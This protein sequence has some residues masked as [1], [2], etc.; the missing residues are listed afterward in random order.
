MI[1][2]LEF[3]KIFIEIL[4]FIS[5]YSKKNFVRPVADILTKQKRGISFISFA[6]WG[7]LLNQ[8]NLI[9]NIHVVISKLNHVLCF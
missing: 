1:L 5:F 7:F 9:Y 2:Y 6:T 8:S 3:E 4:N